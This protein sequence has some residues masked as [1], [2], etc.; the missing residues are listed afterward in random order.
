[1]KQEH[2]LMYAL[3]FVLGFVVARMMS[4][5]LVEGDEG[6]ADNSDCP[7]LPLPLDF[8]NKMEC[9]DFLS[10]LKH[11]GLTKEDLPNFRGG[12]LDHYNFCLNFPE[13]LQFPQLIKLHKK[14]LESNKGKK[15]KCNY[16]E[17]PLGRKIVY[18]D[19][20]NY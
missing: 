6:N 4:G 7:K 8:G 16:E 11:C 14:V 18:S 20:Y 2:L 10:K 19:K 9:E 17:C 1:M 3:V 13:P 15:E 5:S 12:P